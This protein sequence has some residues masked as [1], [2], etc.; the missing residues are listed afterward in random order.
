MADF[1]STT[2]P[3]PMD[4]TGLR[5]IARAGMGEAPGWIGEG[6]SLWQRAPATLL[7]MGVVATLLFF[8]AHMVP[9]LGAIIAM[10]FWP[11]LSAGLFLGFRR[12]Y[13]GKSVTLGDLFRPFRQPGTLAGAGGVYLGLSILAS[14]I[15]FAMLASQLGMAEIEAMM[16]GGDMAAGKSME[17]WFAALAIPALLFL[18]FMLLITMGFLFA[19]ILIHQHGQGVWGAIMLSFKAC[20]R[21]LPAFILLALC[22]FGILLLL[23]LLQLV[24]F[25]GPILWLLISM[26]LATFVIGS[27]YAAYLDLFIRA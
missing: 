16:E 22:W 19:P 18:V 27:L 4:E 17:E 23:G 2:D 13:E 14:V 1:E 3:R 20:L 25:L 26:G 7:G 11:H 21:N 24:P 12:A 5:P 9:F 15:F 8:L 6:F 10:V